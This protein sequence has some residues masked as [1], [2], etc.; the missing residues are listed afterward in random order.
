MT[1]K[2][3]LAELR[4]VRKADGD[5][6]FYCWGKLSKELQDEF[7]SWCE[8]YMLVS[9][10]DTLE[11]WASGWKKYREQFFEFLGGDPDKLW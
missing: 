1:P 8:N 3:M 5:T 7:I 11:G 6:T 2:E 10:A 9:H 4:R